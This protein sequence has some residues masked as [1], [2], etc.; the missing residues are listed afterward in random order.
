MMYYFGILSVTK[1]RRVS[2]LIL[3]FTVLENYMNRSHNYLFNYLI[4]YFIN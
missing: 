3:F 1:Q 2:V 4:I